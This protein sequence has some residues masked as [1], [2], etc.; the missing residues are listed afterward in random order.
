MKKLISAGIIVGIVLS[1]AVAQGNAELDRLDEKISSHLATQF[2]GWR[3]KRVEPVA[4]SSTVLVQFWSSANRVVKVSVAIHHSTE[5]AKREIQDF[6]KFR[7]PQE[8]RGFGD[9]A[10]AAEPEGRTIVFRRGRYVIYLS[11]VADVEGDSD[12]AS[13]SK[14][15]RETRQKAEV[16]RIG[17][18]FAKQVS[19]IEFQ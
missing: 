2:P 9:E 4:P 5:E 8:L 19:S 14:A 16:Q 11:T 13:L 12:A 6:L 7:Q 3:H 10:F 1:I 18:E 15:E 17:K